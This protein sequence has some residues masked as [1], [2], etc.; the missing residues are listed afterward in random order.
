MIVRLSHNLSSQTPFYEGL[1]QPRL[2]QLYSLERGDVCNSFYVTTSNHAGT[3]VDA[4]NHF[5]PRGR[6]IADYEIE[7]LIFTRPAL[8]DI[9]VEESELIRPGH[10]A[11]PAREDCDMLLVR[12]GFGARRGD[13]RTYVDRAPGFS[14]AAAEYLLRRFPS[15]RALA[16]D[17]VSIAAMAHEHEGAEAHRVFLGCEGYS[18]RAVLLVEDA[19]LDASLAN[20]AKVYI[21]PWFVEGLDS[22]P[23]TVF[24]E[25]A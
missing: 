10:L 9:E 21:V 20:L 23:C 3:H 12:S 18:D 5:N 14:R 15:L 16:V 25:T 8:L 4:P 17:F 2:D 13:V 19:R 22:A 6:R 1:E 11:G 7:E 24:A